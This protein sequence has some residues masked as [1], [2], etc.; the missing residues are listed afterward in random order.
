MSDVDRLS[1]LSGDMKLIYRMLSKHAARHVR[2]QVSAVQGTSAKLIVDGDLIDMFYP[3]LKQ[4]YKI[5]AG[6]WIEALKTGEGFI[7]LGPAAVADD[8][9]VPRTSLEERIQALENA[10]LATRITDLETF[11]SNVKQDS[12]SPVAWSAL[13]DNG[14]HGNERHDPD[15]V[16][17]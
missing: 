5:Q 11:K 7:I 8:V 9:G 17:Q 3:M 4:T 16:R 6:D 1:E 12:S 14:V 13:P 2:A 15:F 10:N